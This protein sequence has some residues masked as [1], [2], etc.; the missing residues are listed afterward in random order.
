[1][2]SELEAQNMDTEFKVRAVILELLQ[3]KMQAQTRLDSDSSLEVEQLQ[4]FIGTIDNSIQQFR[5]SG[6][7]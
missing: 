4:S 6:W 1:M 5:F 2:T 7:W 3:L